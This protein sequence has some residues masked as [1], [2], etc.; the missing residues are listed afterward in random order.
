MVWERS[1]DFEVT[2]TIRGTEELEPREMEDTIEWMLEMNGG[3]D[4][5]E[6]I[7]AEPINPEYLSGESPEGGSK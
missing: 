2:M 5:V 6:S 3:I 4:S 7:A 1:A